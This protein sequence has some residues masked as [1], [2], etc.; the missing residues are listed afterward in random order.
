MK[1]LSRGGKKIVS[2]VMYR[3]GVKPMRIAKYV[4]VSRATVYRY[5]KGA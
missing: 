4:N 5:I 3:F 2:K 1:F